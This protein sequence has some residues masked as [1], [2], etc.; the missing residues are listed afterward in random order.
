MV[1]LAPSPKSQ[2]HDKALVLRS[3][4]NIELPATKSPV[5]EK[6]AVGKGKAVTVTGEDNL[7]HERAL[8]CT[9]TV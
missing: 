5:A 4:K 3:E 9:V 2:L 7:V 6:V 8:Y 1:A